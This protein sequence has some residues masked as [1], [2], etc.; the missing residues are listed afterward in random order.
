M[1]I[2]SSTLYDSPA[3]TRFP[4]ALASVP[5]T[6]QG[7]LGPSTMCQ[8][9]HAADEDFIKSS[10]APENSRPAWPPS[11]KHNIPNN[12]H[13]KQGK[14]ARL[15]ARFRSPSPGIWALLASGTGR[16]ASCP[17][18]RARKSL[19]M[20]HCGSVRHPWC[21]A[22]LAPERRT[23]LSAGAGFEGG[24]HRQQTKYPHSKRSAFTGSTADARRAGIQLAI[25]AM[26]KRNKGAARNVSVSCG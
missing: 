8:G 9:E 12:L 22:G 26:A 20:G 10:Y 4:Q 18:S 24:A 15:I 21:A 11:V 6:P 3:E 16:G 14:E 1:P 17:L 5:V 7:N 2:P 23:P 13:H 25:I 19:R